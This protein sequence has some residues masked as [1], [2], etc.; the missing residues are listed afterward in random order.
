[1]KYQ[2]GKIYQILN[3]ETDD[4]YV[5]STCQKLS[6]RMANHRTQLKSGR[7]SKLYD[8]MYEIGEEKFY[9][10]L[11]EEYPCENSEQLLKREGEW[12]RRI[13]TLNENVAGRTKKEY[14]DEN[15]NIK[16]QKAK[17]HYQ[18]NKEQILQRQREHYQENKERINERHKKYNEAHK[19][20][21]QA[22]RD[23]RKEEKTEYNKTYYEKKKEQVDNKNKQW[24]N[25]N[26]IKIVCEIC[27]RE[28]PKFDKAH[29]IQRKYHLDALNNLNHSNNVQLQSDNLREAGETTKGEEV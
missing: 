17:E 12:M 24:I 4:V 28:Y 16:N 25:N 19:E 2:D 6:K 10:E 26:R 18:E 14:A 20:E 21:I 29:H 9:I 15:R 3:S 13:A 27:N 8:K 1:M 23:A 7:V 11:I 22:Y 5:G